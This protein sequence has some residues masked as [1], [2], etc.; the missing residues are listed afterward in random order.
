[1]KTT[2]RGRYHKLPGEKGGIPYTRVKKLIHG[3]MVWVKVYKSAWAAGDKAE[4]KR[5][6]LKPNS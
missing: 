2:R 6:G 3:Q 1:M 5:L 4:R